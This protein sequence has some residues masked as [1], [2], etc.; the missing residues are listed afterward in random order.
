MP[1]LSTGDVLAGYR[2]EG[3]IGRGGMGVVYRATQLALERQVALKLIAPELAQDESFR[4]RFKRE[5]KA[6][7]VIEHAHVIPVHEAGEADGQLYIAMRFIEGI[8]LRELIRREG[9]IDPERTGRLLAQITSALDAAHARGLVHRDIKP[10]NVLIAAEDGREHAYLTDFGLSKRVGSDSGMT[11]TGMWVGTVDY[12]APEQIQGSELDAR[13]DVYSLG[14]LLYHTLTGRVPFER[15]TD[16]AKIFAHMSEPPPPL[17]EVTGGLPDDLDPVLRRAMAKDPDERYPS[18]GDLGRAAR[19]AIEGRPVSQPERSVATGDAAPVAPGRGRAARA[20]ISPRWLLAA[21]SALLVLVIVLAAA[22]AFSGGDEGS[23]QETAAFQKGAVTVTP[24]RVDSPAGVALGAG[25]VWVTS[26]E[27]D[28]VSRIDSESGEVGRPIAVGDGPESVVVGDGT[29]WVVNNDA[30]TL[31]RVDIERGE[32][33][34]NPIDLPSSTFGD[35]I[36]VGGAKVFVALPDQGRVLPIDAA[37]GEPGRRI[38]PPDGVTGE[39]AFGEGALWVVGDRGTVSR[40]DP[41]TGEAGEPVEVGKEIPEDGT[42]RGQI[43]V[44]AG[45]V[46]VAGLDDETVARVDP[47]SGDVV[48]KIRFEDGIEGD[49]AVGEGA[50]WVV[51]ESSRLVRI[52][53]RTNAVAGS[54]LPAG[55]AGANDMVA[56]AGAIWVAGDADQDTVSRIA[57]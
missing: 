31:S 24:I 49:L 6:A 2:I 23:G 48:K 40:I 35:S 1:E 10:G 50:V 21:V 37:S 55:A 9:R 26:Y 41:D 52:D 36:A 15:D 38:E 12:I 42:F 43:A 13:S 20:G 19:A 57:P 46:W 8:D 32:V 17:G 47:R 3:Q 34:G 16:V 18:A 30:G 28:R 51:D 4:E 33:V 44:G 29:V 39:L 25:G 56:G 22:G 14:C 54:R 11:R 27:R 53:P 45:A 5:S 7:A